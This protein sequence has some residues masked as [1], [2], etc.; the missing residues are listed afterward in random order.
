VLLASEVVASVADALESAEPLVPE[1]D[2]SVVAESDAVA[3][4]VGDEVGAPVMPPVPV[5]VSAP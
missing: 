3:L 4:P 2:M 1:A 5:V